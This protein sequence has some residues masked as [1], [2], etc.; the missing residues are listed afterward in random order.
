M[1]Q[2]GSPMRLS[3]TPTV[4]ENPGPASGDSTDIVLAELGYSQETIDQ[5]ADR[6]VVRVARLA[7]L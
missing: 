6:H 4:R 1:R 7:E 2:M 3:K 5:L